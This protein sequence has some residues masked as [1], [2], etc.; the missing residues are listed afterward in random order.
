[1]ND[2]PAQHPTRR[3]DR[4]RRR[5][6]RGLAAAAVL[7]AAAPLAAA[8]GAGFTADS[9]SVRPNAGAGISGPLRINNV[10]VVVDQRAA[11]AQVIGAVANTGTAAD[12]VTGARASGVRALVTGEVSSTAI[13]CVRTVVAAG[14]VVVPPN[15]S[16]GFGRPG[17]PQ[18]SLLGSIRFRPGRV[19]TVTLMFARA[20]PLTVNAQIVADTGLF[21]EYKPLVRIPTPTPSPTRRVIVG[22]TASGTASPTATGSASASPTASPTASGT[23]TPTPTPS[24]TP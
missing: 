14:S 23:P 10:W 6:I 4:S 1:M 15:R 24:A 2:L 12:R 13:G 22:S 9:Q 3:P 21:T 7:L 19:A 11:Y 20:A 5:S 8:C 16:V 18:L 17:C